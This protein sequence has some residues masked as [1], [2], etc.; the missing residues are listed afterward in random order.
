MY[1][2]L[3]APGSVIIDGSRLKVI[4][5]YIYLKQVMVQLVK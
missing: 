2:N 5:E 3:V 1:N 4:K